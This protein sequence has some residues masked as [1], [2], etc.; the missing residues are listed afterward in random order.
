MRSTGNG[1][2]PMLETLH[3]LSKITVMRMHTNGSTIFLQNRS[4]FFAET[5][6]IFDETLVFGATF[7]GN[8]YFPANSIFQSSDQMR[9]LLDISFFALST[10][11]RVFTSV[12][13]ES[14]C[15]TSYERKTFQTFLRTLKEKINIAIVL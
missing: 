2:D 3:F 9:L 10:C 8:D 7:G 4:I 6:M 5:L 12:S 14:L 11:M 1:H 13:N 15:V